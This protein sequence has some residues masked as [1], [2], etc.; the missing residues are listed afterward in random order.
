MPPLQPGQP[1]DDITH[2]VER[3]PA[4]KIAPGVTLHTKD[5]SKIGNAIV[6]KRNGS[7]SSVPGLTRDFIPLWRIE[8]DFGNQIPA[9]QESEILELWEL[10][11]V[12]NYDHWWESR[13]L[14]I[15]RVL[16][17]QDGV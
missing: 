9:M 2:E 16:G 8:T 10:G 13:L 4:T 1:T 5:G 12:S 7:T 11:Y 17:L 3:T 6:V 15:R 14:T